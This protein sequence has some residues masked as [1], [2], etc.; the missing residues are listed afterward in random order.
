M[1]DAIKGSIRT[2]SNKGV[3]SSSAS[4]PPSEIHIPLVSKGNTTAEKE[5]QARAMN[6]FNEYMKN[7]KLNNDKSKLEY[8]QGQKFL[9]ITYKDPCYVYTPNEHKRETFGGLKERLNLPDGTFAEYLS[10][11]GKGRNLLP[12]AGPV[13]IPV[14]VLDKA[15]GK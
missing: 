10:G 6:N 7:G 3:H 9:G 2:E 13:E 11:Y 4:T 12:M 5:K 15:I 14:K 8:V 1:V